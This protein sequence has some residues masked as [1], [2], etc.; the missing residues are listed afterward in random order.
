M[1]SNQRVTEVVGKPGKTWGNV[2]VPASGT[3]SLQITRD[4]IQA[5]IKNGFE[6]TTSWTRIQNIDSV[7]IAES[8]NYL[9]FAIG[10]PVAIMGLGG[11]ANDSAILGLVFLAIGIACIVFAIKEK[12]RLLVIHS[13]RYTVPIFMTKPPDVYQ[14]FGQHVMVM[15]RQLNAPAPQPNRFAQAKSTSGISSQLTKVE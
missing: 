3:I 13:F 11:L 5:T 4:L 6:K 2:I 1:Q 14:Q 10:I 7:E 12:R 8:P 15:A 9:L